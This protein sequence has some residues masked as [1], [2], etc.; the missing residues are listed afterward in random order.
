MSTV[1]YSL[2]IQVNCKTLVHEGVE[3]TVREVLKEVFVIGGLRKLIKKVK[4]D[5]T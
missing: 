2:V 5:C 3:A 4:S 1:L